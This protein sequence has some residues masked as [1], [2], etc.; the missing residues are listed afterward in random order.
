M[1]VLLPHPDPASLVVTARE[2]TDL[3]AGLRLTLAVSPSGNLRL[4]ESPDEE[5]LDP[6]PAEAIAAAFPRGPAEGLF[7]LGAAEI[8]AGR[9]TALAAGQ[10]GKRR[11]IAE[12]ALA[13]V[14][15]IEIDAPVAAPPAATPPASRGDGVR[16]RRRAVA[17]PIEAPGPSTPGA[18]GGRRHRRGR[19]GWRS[20]GR[21]ATPRRRPGAT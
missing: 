2:A 15:G 21:P 11:R 7:H 20:A 1:T 16:P 8:E 12:S 5:P 18:R 17:K 6:K 13:D 19:T 9:G 14:F 3:L 4:V 10:D